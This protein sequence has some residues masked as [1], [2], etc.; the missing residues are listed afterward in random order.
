MLGI[1]SGTR[2]NQHFLPDISPPSLF[3][4]LKILINFIS[5]EQICYHHMHNFTLQKSVS[6]PRRYDCRRQRSIPLL[7][8]PCR[9]PRSL[10]SLDEA[11]ILDGNS[12][13]YLRWNLWSGSLRVRSWW[14]QLSSGTRRTTSSTAPSSVRIRRDWP[15]LRCRSP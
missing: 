3:L 12:E 15:S 9:S 4:S 10:G 8:Y 11:S 1:A 5:F 14:H 13:R 7:D 2:K 6:S